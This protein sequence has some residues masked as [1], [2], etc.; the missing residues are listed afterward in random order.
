MRADVFNCF[1]KFIRSQS[2]EKPEPIAVSVDEVL[3]KVRKTGKTKVK[4]GIAT[5]DKNSK[6]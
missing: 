2:A 4:A 1:I 3:Q 5:I 6:K